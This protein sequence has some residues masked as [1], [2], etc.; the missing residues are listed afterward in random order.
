M[1]KIVRA[2]ISVSNKQG[3]VELAQGLAALGVE[4]L[5]TGGTAKI[6]EEAGVSVVRIEEYTGFPEILDGRVK[7]LHPK[8]YGGILGQRDNP[9]HQQQLSLHGLPAIDLVAV[10]LYPFEQT[11]AEPECPLAEAIENI[12]IGGPT[13]IRAAAKNYKD[14]AVVTDPADYPAIL[15]EMR[16]NGGSLAL[17]SKF[18]LAKKAFQLTARYDGAIA[19]YLGSTDGEQR[20]PIDKP[21]GKPSGK[22]F[23]D[24][25]HLQFFKAQD[26]RYGENPHQ[27]ATFYREREINEPS[28]ASAR[29]LQ[30]KE[31]SFNN[32]VDAN[33]ALELLREFVGEIAAV[34]IKHTNPC[35]V[36]ISTI[37]AA[38][39]FRKAWACDPVS[40]FGGIV[41]FNREVDEETAE[42]ILRLYQQGFLEIVIAPAFSARAQELLASSKRLQNI[43]LLAVSVPAQPRLSRYEVKQVVGG[44]LLQ[45][46]DLG[47]VQVEDCRVVTRRRP[48]PA[49]YR[50]LGFGW[51]VCKHVK[52][53]AIVFAQEDRVIGVGA[54]Q[55]SRVDAAKV[56]ILRAQDLGL[57][58]QGTVVAS[59]AFFPFRDGVDVAA[60]A[61]A[62]AIIQPGGSLRDR[63]VIEAADEHGLAM[64]FTQMRHF[65]H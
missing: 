39:A 2:L 37:S 10:N 22:P 64:V 52:S 8:I 46:R 57:D 55:M 33:A 19:D 9:A 16:A 14:V 29:Q 59:D 3:V 56:A 47:R 38:D 43:R 54:G 23:S 41:G 17:A 1:S 42:E 63:E 28:I 62:R 6:L 26:L 30:G 45:E 20:Q 5:S 61:G 24:T 18:R 15:A 60:R 4:I 44:L 13:L 27:A 7:T 21:S 58:P 32:I 36:A 65:R 48:T 49:E 31:L 51:K 50:A 53:N 35:G 12:D 25:L 11:V 34:A 40:I